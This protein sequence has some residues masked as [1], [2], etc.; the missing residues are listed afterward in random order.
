[1]AYDIASALTNSNYALRELR[2][3]IPADYA[4][5]AAAITIAAAARE[6]KDLAAN[7]RA[8]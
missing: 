3:G 5:S 7:A 6:A 2:R 1:M 4:C 8:F